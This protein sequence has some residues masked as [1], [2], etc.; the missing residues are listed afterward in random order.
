MKRRVLLFAVGLLLVAVSSCHRDSVFRGFEK[1]ENGAYMKFYSR[2]GSGLCPRL[3]DRVTFEMSQ[4][5]ND[6]LVFTTVGDEPLDIELREADFVGDVTD[7]LLMMQVGDSARLV[8]LADSIFIAVMETDPP[9]DYA[10]KPIHYDLKLL[11]IK[12]FEEV[13]AENQR[14]LDSM[15]MEERRFLEALKAD[16]KTTV[17]G[18]GL[19]IQELK[20]RGKVAQI[21]DYVDFDFLMCSK[22]GDTLMSSF[23]VESV[24]MQYGEE[25][26]CE[27]FNTALAMVPEGGVMR[28]VIPSELGFDSIGYQ[29]MVLPY[30]PLVVKLRMNKVMD[31]AA[32]KKNVEA[33]KA[34]EEAERQ[35]RLAMEKTLIDKYLKDND[36]ASTPTESGVYLI[37]K[38]EGIGTKAEWGD[39]VAVHYTLCNLHG[40]KIESSYDFGEPMKFT[41]G[42]GEMIPCIEE[43]VMTMAPGAKVT[44]VS[45]SEQAFGE[46]AIHNELLPAH[47]P[48]LVEMELVAIE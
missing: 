30:E 18:S 27:G 32:H 14:A 47:S 4:Y 19:L 16:P 36:V 10:G 24:D 41:I 1:M 11:S 37:V 38:E 21:G 2:S 15:R 5:F 13:N 8:V 28:F 26:I 12:P 17:D 33:R 35:R 40:D 31:D 7:G 44:V 46:F 23:D 48:L 3:N 20:G 29:G 22:D 25:F 43:A 45:P 34:K 9:E 42:K 6:T 39:V